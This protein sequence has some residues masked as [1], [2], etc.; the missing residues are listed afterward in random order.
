MTDQKSDTKLEV[1]D[2]GERMVIRKPIKFN[3]FV[4]TKIDKYYIC[5]GK[6]PKDK[7]H[8]PLQSPNR[9]T[10]S[11]SPEDDNE[12]YLKYPDRLT[13][14]EKKELE[15]LNIKDI[16]DISGENNLAIVLNPKAHFGFVL[17][18]TK[19]SNT[20]VCI[21]KILKIPSVLDESLLSTVEPLTDEDS[22]NIFEYAYAPSVLKELLSEKKKPIEKKDEIICDV[23]G[24][25]GNLGHIQCM[26]NWCKYYMTYG[27]DEETLIEMREGSEE[28][29]EDSDDTMFCGMCLICRMED[30]DRIMKMF[31]KHTVELQNSK[32]SKWGIL[33][34]Q[35]DL[36]VPDVS[37][38]Y[39]PK[40][41]DIDLL[42]REKLDM[43]RDL[44]KITFEKFTATITKNSDN[45][46]PHIMKKNSRFITW[47][48]ILKITGTNQS[49]CNISMNLPSIHI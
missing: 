34:V 18:P 49:R 42:P 36:L 16:I 9:S 43:S 38:S 4:L 22:K 5:L 33:Y 29:S 31:H 23:I 6:I 14:D 17:A 2:V 10:R 32:D 11:A 20:S 27:S 46:M 24:C 8:L 30:C 35:T 7:T 26:C 3:G 39:F 44:S 48:N 13:D 15:S 40:I 25:V 47:D 45:S 21:G 41:Y 19:L 12:Y 1:D 28:D 37:I